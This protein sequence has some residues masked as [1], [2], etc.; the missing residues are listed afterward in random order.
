VSDA[1]IHDAA[2]R[3]F[4]AAADRY[5]RGRPSYPDDAVEFLVRMLR[6][7]AG[8]DVVELGAGTGKF[9]ELLVPTGARIVALEPVPAMRE[10]LARNVPSVS[11]ADGTA[12]RIPLGDTSADAVVAAQAFHWFDGDRA[13]PEIHRVLRPGAGLG[14][15]WNVRDEASDWSERLT[16]IFD[17]LAGDGAPRYRDM[18]WRQA[19]A[20][21]G[22]FG[23]LHHQLAYHV[24]KVTREQFVDRVLSVSYVASAP[25]RERERVDAEVREMLDTDPEL[26]DRDQIVMPYR[27]DVYWSTRR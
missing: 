1:R 20:R 11:V 2:A 19:F 15:I 9:T 16:K 27:T 4:E 25:E 22:L 3:G 18:R 21:S 6:I 24:H 5:E 7:R 10:A 14:L 26:R 12:E 8:S 13:L 23:P 17:R